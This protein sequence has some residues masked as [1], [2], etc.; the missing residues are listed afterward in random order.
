MF[1]PYQ[2][3]L[4]LHSLGCKNTSLRPSSWTLKETQKQQ[5][6]RRKL[7]HLNLKIISPIYLYPRI[8]PDRIFR[9]IRA[10]I[11]GYRLNLRSSETSI[12]GY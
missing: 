10:S 2:Y 11:L 8:E 5:T 9:N 7:L 12:Y 4:F 6:L 1:V 3:Q